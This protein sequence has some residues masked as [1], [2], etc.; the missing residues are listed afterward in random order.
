M[1]S[2]AGRTVARL[3]IEQEKYNVASFKTYHVNNE[4]AFRG[5]LR[6][7][8]L[9]DFAQLG[10]YC[11]FLLAQLIVL[12]VILPIMLRAKDPKVRHTRVC[13]M[14]AGLVLQGTAGSERW[15][16]DALV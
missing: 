14:V 10:C 11:P 16:L 9:E 3:G 5:M 7:T 1:K 6:I 13:M 2:I 8:H 15:S 12:K 4:S